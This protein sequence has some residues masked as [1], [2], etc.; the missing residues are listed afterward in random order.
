MLDTR[1]I[2]KLLPHRYPF[3]LVDRIIEI[4]PDGSRAVGIKNVT[5]DEWF[6]Q[7]HFP[8]Y[9]IV[10]GVLL[11]EALA[12]VGGVALL[13]REA[14]QGKMGLLAGVDNF[15]FRR[16]V[17]PGDTLRLEVTVVKARGSVARLSGRATVEGQVVAEGDILVAVANAE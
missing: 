1:E 12:Q 3:L 2:M 7:G 5:A 4:A 15:R 14:Y 17:T 16:P 8:D 10:P 9:P 6:F 11:V 13:S